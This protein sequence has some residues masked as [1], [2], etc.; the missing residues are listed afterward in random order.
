MSPAKAYKTAAK[1][2]LVSCDVAESYRV[3]FEV[4]ALLS[5]DVGANVVMHVRG[6]IVH[7]PDEDTEVTAGAF[8]G[9]C[10]SWTRFI[11]CGQDFLDVFDQDGELSGI[12]SL[13]WDLEKDEYR[14]ALGLGAE[15]KGDLIIPSTMEILPEHRG[16]GVGLL[17]LWR[18]LDYFGKSASLA[19]L[20]PYPLNHSPEA[21][22]QK[23]YLP[24]Q[25]DRLAEVP[26]KK[27]VAKIGQHWRK[28]GFKPVPKSLQ[29]G[30]RE[31]DDYLYL[32]MP[33]ELPMLRELIARST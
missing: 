23:N 15:D 21:K 32:D 3:R 8:Q 14:S 17:V 6:K 28:L 25:Y 30:E 19:L 20:K 24:M 27:G 16:K 2:R 1:P 9:V 33:G 18:F 4:D 12:A 22:S 10:V 5:D 7:L 31:A 13:V 29:A 11:D 26:L